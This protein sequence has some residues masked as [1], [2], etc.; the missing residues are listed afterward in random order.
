MYDLSKFQ[1]MMVC[2]DLTEMDKGLIQYASMM[3]KVMEIDSVYFLHVAESLELPA[4]VQEKY[5]DLAAPLDETLEHEIKGNVEKYFK[6]PVKCDI[7]IKVATGRVT[8]EV[9]K[10]AKVKVIDLLILGR[11]HHRSNQGLNSSKIAKSS[12][13]SVMYVPENPKLD[14]NRI[15]IPI[16]YS[17]HSHMAFEIGMALQK[18]TGAK[19]MTNHIY[20]VPKGYY[21]SGKNYDEFAEI[22]LDNTR[23]DS[24][25]FFRKIGV[26]G[27]KFE[28]TFAL[29]DDPHPADKIYKTASEKGCDLIVLG[30]KGRTSAAA[31]LLGSVAEKLVYESGDIPLFLVKKG[32]ENLGLLEALFR[33]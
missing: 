5:P 33:L 22:M 20:R 1:R 13:A 7:Q 32:R 24:D 3:A 28:H 26:D 27:L 11:R 9:I 19:I 16:D 23:K 21:K 18:Q 8:E 17:E 15:L 10:M 2:L 14:L 29:D 31:F 4:E 25:R 12:P 30:S 6:A